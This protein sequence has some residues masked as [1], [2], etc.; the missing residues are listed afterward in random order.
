M[1]TI[2]SGGSLAVVSFAL[3]R[4]LTVAEIEDASGA[5]CRALLDPN[6]RAPEDM[7]PRILNKLG[8]KY[9]DEPFALEMARAAPFS[10]LGGLAEGAKFADDLRTAIGVLTK[11]SAVIADHLELIFDDSADEGARLISRHPMDAIDNGRSHE[12]G[13]GLV[14]RLF[15]DFLGIRDCLDSVTFTHAPNC[16]VVYYYDHFGVP[17]EFEAPEMALHFKQEKLPA[18]IKCA[19]LDLFNYVMTHL[20][21]LQ[22]QSETFDEPREMSMLRKA[23]ADNAHAGVFSASS[24]AAA[25]NMSLRSAQRLTSEHGTSLLELIET[26]R[27]TRAK[28]LLTEPRNDI[29]AIAFLL[30]Y[31]DDRAFRRAFHR[32]TGKSP[33]E[34]K[35]DMKK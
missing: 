28:Q 24:A 9:P 31:S 35:N 32:W 4:G 8:D 7:M 12:V 23:A 16:S 25:A 14:A 15:T 6:S 10:Y 19:N 21:V 1:S 34:F 27:K 3:S 13:I 33:S 20:S 29:S 11:N 30:G 22:K 5:S 18:K 26:A 17:V 2:S